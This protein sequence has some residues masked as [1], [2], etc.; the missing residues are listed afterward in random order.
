MTLRELLAASALSVAALASAAA[1]A[2]AA[3]VAQEAG[4]QVGATVKDT[5]GGVVGTIAAIN[6][7]NVT[8]RTDRHEA[9]VPASSFAVSN[10]EVYFGMTQAQLNAAVEQA[11]AQAQAAFAVGTPVKDRNGVV[12]GSVQALDDN[13]VTIQMGEQQVRL[14]RTALAARDGALVTG[15]TV[16]E[17][18]AAVN[19]SGT[20]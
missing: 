9:T 2:P 18:Q 7:P 13:F 12:V 6:G 19:S 11:Q 10:G 14:P 8:I 4:L 5:E 1:I 17:L 15:A 20:Q 3:A 16:A